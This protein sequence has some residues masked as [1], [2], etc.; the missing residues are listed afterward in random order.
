MISNL[1][2]IFFSLVFAA[3]VLRTNQANGN[4]YKLTP[5]GKRVA[6]ALFF[7]LGL[8]INQIALHLYWTGTSYTW[9]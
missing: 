9:L 3:I 4:P 6:F 1:I 8:L 2:G 5:R 7:I